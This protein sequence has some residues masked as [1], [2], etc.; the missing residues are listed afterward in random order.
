MILTQD[1]IKKFE[2]D[3][4]LV[5]TNFLTAET[6]DILKHESD[7]LLKT[8]L[9]NN[10]ASVFSNDLE[11]YQ[12]MFES[13]SKIHH[14]MDSDGKTVNKLGHAVH[15]NEEF[16][17]ITFSEP[18]RQIAKSLDF[19]EP[20]VLQSMVIFK[21]PGAEELGIH[22]DETFLYVEPSKTLGFWIALE[23]VTEDNSCLEFVPGSHLTNSNP[24]RWVRDGNKMK[25]I[26]LNKETSICKDIP[27]K[28]P[29]P[30]G[31]LILI[32]G[33]VIH[34]SGANTSTRSRYAYT[35]H[36][37]E[38]HETKFPESNWMSGKGEKLF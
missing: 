3:G 19:V 27:I 20:I 12:Y 33:Q 7:D 1:Q 11:S 38:T 13:E 25:F 22:R 17:Q 37:I 16:H 23:D 6:C 24:Q 31:T 34:K 21:F 15:K 29:C 18:I 5:I 2:T 35:F 10:T 28:V 26:S 8:S 14:F 9:A 36:I 30:K 32:S 4:F